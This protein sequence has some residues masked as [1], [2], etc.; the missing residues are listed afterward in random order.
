MQQAYDNQIQ[1]YL[2]SQWVAATLKLKILNQH[3]STQDDIDPSMSLLIKKKKKQHKQ[4][5]L[6]S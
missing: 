4:K 5:S 2:F 1:E 3:I 6:L